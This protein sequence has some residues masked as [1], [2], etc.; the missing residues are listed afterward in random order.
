[1]KNVA[2]VF[3]GGVGRTCG[4]LRNKGGMNDVKFPHINFYPVE[5]SIK[6]HI[7]DTNP[8][9]KFD[10]FMHCWN[11]D[12]EKE[13]IELYKPK[14]YLFENNS[15]YEKEIENKIKLSG[16]DLDTFGEIS[17]SI[18]IKKGCELLESYCEETNTKY[19]FII[20]LRPDYLYWKDMFLDLYDEDKIYGTQYGNADGQSHYVMNYENMKKFKNL[21]DNISNSNPP[22]SHWFMMRY[23]NSFM[24]ELHKDSFYTGVDHE[25]VR[26]LRY[27]IENGCLPSECLYKYGLTMEEIYSYYAD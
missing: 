6:Q 23:I 19:N 25:S 1:M 21:Y 2:L 11:E 12:L 7:I 9:Y 20:S 3:R 8:E 10:T 27:Q 26:K 18:S 16:S 22:D 24:G 14:K 17:V 5:K 15:L 4:K 13:L